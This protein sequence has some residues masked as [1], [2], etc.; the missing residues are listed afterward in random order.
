MLVKDF[1]VDSDVDVLALTE[2]WLRPGN[3]DDIKIGTLR[4]IGYRFLHVP[5]PHGRGGGVGISFKETLNVNTSLTDIFDTFEL[6]DVRLRNLQTVR[7]LVIYRPPNN[8]S[9]NQFL[10]EFS[11]LLENTIAESSGRLLI[12][13]DF[14]LHMDCPSDVNVK[15]FIDILE[16]FDL[17]QRVCSGTH[18][19]G[20]TLDLLINKSD[21]V[22]MRNIMVHDPGISDHAAVIC[23]LSLQKP[24]FRKKVVY[25]RKLRSMDIDSFCKDVSSSSLVNDYSTDLDTLVDQYD[26]VLR[27][28]LDKHAP[29]KQRLV[30]VRPAAP[31]YTA[32]VTDEKRKRRRLERKWRKTRLEVDR[33]EYVYQCGVVNNLIK[34]LKSAYYT[35]IITEH[36]TDQR[37][38]FNT[39]KKLLQKPSE[40]RYPP[41][42]DGTSLANS[43]ADFFTSKIERIHGSL[44]EK[45]IADT[46]LEVN[47]PSECTSEFQNFVSV[48]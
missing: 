30:T 2:T 3:V 46:G 25:F 43:F 40:V 5:R 37:V 26:T 48:G 36:S 32:E 31:W 41:S 27:S 12:T 42:C 39:V 44:M 34:S 20:H 38:L 29:L 4:P 9:F 1:V 17:K 23:D 35:E 18:L 33:Q 10:E 21:D 15:R 19:S 22:M 13:G 7:I 45:N 16:S 28:I 6:M 8:T 47:L 11:T 24:Q 14:N